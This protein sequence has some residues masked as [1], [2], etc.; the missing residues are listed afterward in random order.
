MKLGLESIELI[1]NGLLDQLTM[2]TDSLM[3]CFP[4]L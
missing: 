2:S 3:A 1:I 4:I